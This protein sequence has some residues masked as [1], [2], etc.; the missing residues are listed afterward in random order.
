MKNIILTLF[1]SCVL[2]I[3]FQQADKNNTAEEQPGK[4]KAGI[5]LSK[6]DYYEKQMKMKNYS[7]IKK[8]PCY[9]VDYMSDDTLAFYIDSQST[10]D[11]SAVIEFRFEE[12]CCQ[13]FL[14]DYTVLNDT[15]TFEYQQ[16]NDG[17]C[18]CRCWYEYRL[19]INEMRQ[20]YSTINIK[21]KY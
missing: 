6:K 15:L 16:V 11:S 7:L 20:K 5:E 14:G 8:G 3:S 4:Q 10:T 2:L 21:R 13:E 12:S 18:S 19:E 1:A 17:V 9:D